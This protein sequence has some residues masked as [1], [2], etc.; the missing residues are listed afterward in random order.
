MPRFATID[1]L[2]ALHC[3]LIKCCRIKCPK[4]LAKYAVFVDGTN[5]PEA[6]G[7][8][9]PINIGPVAL[10]L[11]DVTLGASHR[12]GDAFVAPRSA[13]YSAHAALEWELVNA[14]CGA[15][16]T[17]TFFVFAER[18]DAVPVQLA[19]QQH[20]ISAQ[21][22]SRRSQTLIALHTVPAGWGVRVRVAFAGPQVPTLLRVVG[23]AGS[24]SA[25]RSVLNIIEQ[26]TC[27]C[28]TACIE[29]CGVKA[30]TSECVRAC[31]QT[32]GCACD[33]CP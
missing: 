9:V 16:Y 21:E 30:P 12:V 18:V 14:V 2:E 26:E 20:N 3:K 6:Q 33:E 23:K 24:E 4:P 19:R 11:T 27:P 1:Q 7:Q 32:T 25:R 5:D 31:C 13:I 22:Q 28:L 17:V 15:A 8:L 10:E 29:S